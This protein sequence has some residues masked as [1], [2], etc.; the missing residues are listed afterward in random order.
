MFSLFSDTDDGAARSEL[1]VR[2]RTGVDAQGRP[3]YAAPVTVRAV[4]LAYDGAAST[5]GADRFAPASDGSRTTFH[6][7]AYF[8]VEADAPEAADLVT[9]EGVDHY[10][11]DRKVV[12]ALGGALH[13]V[14][15]RLKVAASAGS[16][17]A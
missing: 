15:V 10:V 7:T 4:V 8:D 6:A 11:A 5:G 12:R 14:R 3:S 16:V 17:L 13:H 2:R 9:F 1:I